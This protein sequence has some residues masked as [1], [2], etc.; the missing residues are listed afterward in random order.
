MTAVRRLELARLAAMRVLITQRAAGRLSFHGQE[1]GELVES[2]AYA[3]LPLVAG[4]IDELEL[5]ESHGE[6]RTG[7]LQ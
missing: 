5:V 7:G 2:F 1:L 3:M 4:E 6:R